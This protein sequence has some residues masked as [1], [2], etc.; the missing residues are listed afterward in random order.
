MA[1]GAA[2]QPPFPSSVPSQSPCPHSTLTLA[3]PGHVG[4]AAET[5]LSLHPFSH[6]PRPS[7]E[8]GSLCFSSF[9]V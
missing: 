5:P 3:P 2:T 6:Q 1:E 7:S 9:Q 8:P 4:Q